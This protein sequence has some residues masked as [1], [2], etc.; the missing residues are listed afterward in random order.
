MDVIDIKFKVNKFIITVE[1]GSTN[2][3]LFEVIKY[4]R[5]II[6]D[7]IIKRIKDKRIR[8]YVTGSFNRNAELNV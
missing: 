3:R 7:L 8:K 4:D 6:S 1:K 5:S 2:K